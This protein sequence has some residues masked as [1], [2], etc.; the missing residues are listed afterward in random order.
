[1]GKSAGLQFFQLSG[2]KIIQ[3]QPTDNEPE[4]RTSRLRYSTGYLCTMDC[5]VRF[6]HSWHAGPPL[7]NG[8]VRFGIVLN[9][10]DLPAAELEPERAT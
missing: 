9:A 2:R 4:S 8:Q 1:M 5:A 6:T 7:E 10:R 3:D